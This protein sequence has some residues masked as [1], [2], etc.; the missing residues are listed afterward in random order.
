MAEA[1]TQLEADKLREDIAR[2]E[3]QIRDWKDRADRGDFGYGNAATKGLDPQKAR[4]HQ[5]R[6]EE[7]KLEL[8]ARL[9]ELG[10]EYEAPPTKSYQFDVT[11]STRPGWG[12]QYRAAQVYGNRCTHSVEAQ[13][14]SEGQALAIRDHKENCL[15]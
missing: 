13:S 12:T 1:T 11:E 14:A 5:A 15:K 2:L 8:V 9:R 4:H 7:Q 6:L 3:P 10:F